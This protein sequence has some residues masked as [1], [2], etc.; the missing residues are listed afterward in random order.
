MPRSSL[1][2]DGELRLGL[3]PENVRVAGGGKPTTKAKVELVERLGE[4]TLVYA[5]LADGQSI[6]AE[7]EGNSRVRIGDEVGIRID[8]NA[9]HIFGADGMSHHAR[10]KPA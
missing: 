6:T 8:G 2:S 4:R 5:R 7:D 9:S 3:R 1:Q 10:A